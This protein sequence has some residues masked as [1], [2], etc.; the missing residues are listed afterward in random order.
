MIFQNTHSNSHLSNSKDCTI[1]RQC[2]TT[3]LSTKNNNSLNRAASLTEAE[4]ALEAILQGSLNRRAKES[5]KSY[6][7]YKVISDLIY[8]EPA[9]VVSV[10]KDYLILDDI[11]EFLKRRYN[12][13]DA[14]L[15]LPKLCNFYD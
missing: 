10:F 15:R 13:H 1:C 3:T 7:H 11:N 2:L 8:N 14:S 6:K 4:P 12:K 9:H 5:V